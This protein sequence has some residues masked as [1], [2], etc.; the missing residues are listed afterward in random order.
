MINVDSKILFTMKTERGLK[1]KAQKIAK[2]LGLSLGTLLN[3]LLKQFVRDKEVFLSINGK[4]SKE[5]LRSIH[6]ANLELKKS[7]LPKAV[8]IEGLLSELKS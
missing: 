4:P 1:E 6:K 5:L 2:E 7:K 8:D 3:A